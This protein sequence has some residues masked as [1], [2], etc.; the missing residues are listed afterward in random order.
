MSAVWTSAAAEEPVIWGE[1][2]RRVRGEMQTQAR[3][4]TGN[5]YV[6]RF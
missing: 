2:A 5:N 6:E 4:Y 3:F 1:A